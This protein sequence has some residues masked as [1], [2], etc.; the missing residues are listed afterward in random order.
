MAGH[1]KLARQWQV[2][3]GETQELLRI[4]DKTKVTFPPFAL[5]NDIYDRTIRE[6][7]HA[8]YALPAVYLAG[9]IHG[10]R[11]GRRREV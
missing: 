6:G 5:I 11:A 2:N 3:D 4:Y 7:S 9:Y 1:S 10:V 8:T